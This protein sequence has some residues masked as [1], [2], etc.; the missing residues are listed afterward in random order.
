MKDRIP[1]TDR[2]DADIVRGGGNRS[3]IDMRGQFNVECVGPDGSVKWRTSFRNLVTNAGEDDV[4]D[5]YFKASAYT[6]AHYVGLIDENA[7]SAAE[8]DTMA[9]HAGWTEAQP[10]SET[11]RQTLTMGTVSG[12]SVDNSAAKASFSINTSDTVGGAFVTTDNT[13]GGSTGTLYSAGAFSG[14]NKSV[15]NGDTLNVTYTATAG[16][17]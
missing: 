14:G 5:K 9:S 7:G 1:I 15:G 6:A 10:Y 17:A 13:K 11:V 16:G 8:G 4:L 3:R 2:A 12:Q